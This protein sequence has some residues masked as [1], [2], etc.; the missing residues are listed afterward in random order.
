MAARSSA[1]CMGA[2]IA[3]VIGLIAFAFGLTALILVLLL[4][5]SVETKF[6][7]NYRTHFASLSNLKF[8]F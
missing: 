4:R 3:M 5:S 8:P 6:G 7:S 1:S 2:V